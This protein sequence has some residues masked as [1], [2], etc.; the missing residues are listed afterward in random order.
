MGL[1]HLTNSELV[2]PAKIL[3]ILTKSSLFEKYKRAPAHIR[4][5]NPSHVHPFVA[6]TVLEEITFAGLS[7]N[8][9][10][11]TQQYVELAR[12]VGSAR[13][14]SASRV[15]TLLTDAHESQDADRLAELDGDADLTLAENAATR[16]TTDAGSATGRALD[17]PSLG[18]PEPEPATPE[19]LPPLNVADLDDPQTPSENGNRTGTADDNADPWGSE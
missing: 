11:R 1:P 7:E 19:D 16:A 13:G 2:K 17:I 14:L 3:T 6:R 9:R 4:D 10:E 5:M 15:N 12:A 18:A 8:S